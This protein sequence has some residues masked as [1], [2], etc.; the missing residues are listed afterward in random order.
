M[1]EESIEYLQEYLDRIHDTFLN[2]VNSLEGVLSKAHPGYK[3]DYETW[4]IV[5]IIFYNF[6]PIHEEPPK[7][8]GRRRP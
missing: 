8:Y 7:R 3:I 1:T 5:P 2:T 6:A 4:K